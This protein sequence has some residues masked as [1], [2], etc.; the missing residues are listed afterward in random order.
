LFEDA[1]AVS[2]FVGLDQVNIVLPRTLIGKGLINVVL[3]VDGKVS[4]T[5]QI[6]IK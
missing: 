3:T 1:F 2:G 6:S 5:V 4:N